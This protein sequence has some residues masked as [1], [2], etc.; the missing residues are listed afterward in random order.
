MSEALEDCLQIYHSVYSEDKNLALISQVL[1]HQEMQRI[2]A[3]RDTYVAISLEDIVRNLCG[4]KSALSVDTSRI[5]NLI[6]RM[7]CRICCLPF[8]FRTD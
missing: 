7:V 3:L 5:E 8:N 1:E 2:A 4:S 6:L